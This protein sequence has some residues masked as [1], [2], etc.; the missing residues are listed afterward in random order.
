MIWHEPSEW[1]DFEGTCHLETA[2]FGTQ[3][4]ILAPKEC[5]DVDQ[6]WVTSIDGA[7]PDEKQVTEQYFVKPAKTVVLEWSVV[8]ASCFSYV[9]PWLC[10]IL[11]ATSRAM[12]FVWRRTETHWAFVAM[13]WTVEDI[14]AC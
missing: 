13:V 14:P 6:D 5:L 8:V 1:L 10:L 3:L 9:V 2:E 7:N 11:S 4:Q 12:E